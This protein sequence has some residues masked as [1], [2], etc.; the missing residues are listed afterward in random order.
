MAYEVLSRII[1]LYQRMKRKM[2]V[3]EIRVG[4][5]ASIEGRSF[6]CTPFHQSNQE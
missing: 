3:E 2:N 4:A 6:V 1:N 5:A